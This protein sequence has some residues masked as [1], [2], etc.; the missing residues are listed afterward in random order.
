MQILMQHGADTSIKF[1]SGETVFD[2]DT[3]ENEIMRTVLLSPKT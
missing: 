2:L 1:V 3:S